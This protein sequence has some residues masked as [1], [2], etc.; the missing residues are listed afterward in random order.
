MTTREDIIRAAEMEYGGF[1]NTDGEWCMTRNAEEFKRF[2]EETFGFEVIVCKEIG[3]C[4]AY[5]RTACGLNIAWNG[6][7]RRA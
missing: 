7:C 3:G 2:L 1:V 6:Y 4:T 5:A